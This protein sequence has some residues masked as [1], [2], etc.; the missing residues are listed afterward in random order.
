MKR[1]II[2]ISAIPETQNEYSTIYA[3]CGD[4]TLW[5]HVKDGW[6]Q[7]PDVPQPKHPSEPKRPIGLQFPAC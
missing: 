3:L 1:K 7:L 6:E 2:Q 5:Y 4:G